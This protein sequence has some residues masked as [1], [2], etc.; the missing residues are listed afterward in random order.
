[1]SSSFGRT[2]RNLQQSSGLEVAD[3]HGL[4]IKELGDGAT[5]HRH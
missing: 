4:E 1:M 5:A 2:G 3:I